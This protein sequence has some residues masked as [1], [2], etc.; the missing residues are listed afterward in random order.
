MHKILN[1]LNQSTHYI[2]KA[3]DTISDNLCTEDWELLYGVSDFE[4]YGE[5]DNWPLVE[6]LRLLAT[7][8]PQL[9]KSRI[10]DLKLQCKDYQAVFTLLSLIKVYEEYWIIAYALLFNRPDLFDRIPTPYK[11][12]LIWMLLH[13]KDF[14]KEVE[15]DVVSQRLEAN[16]K[17][18]L[19]I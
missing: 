15:W 17:S 3:I 14:I 13:C 11:E 8:D 18:Q 7:E 9:F 2:S 12:T 1:T 10:L 16:Q 5:N 19:G 6:S 4:D